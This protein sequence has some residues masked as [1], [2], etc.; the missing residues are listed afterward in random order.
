MNS[1]PS[2]A[3]QRIEGKAA[4]V[5]EGMP[6][7]RV[8]PSRLRRMVGA[9]CFLD[10]IGPAT[11]DTAG[12]LRVG[13][14]PHIGLQT[15]TWLVE[16]EILHRDSLGSLQVIKPGQLNVM[17]SGRAISHSEESPPDAPRAIHGV[18]FWTV[19]PEAERWREP[20]FDHYATLPRLQHEGLSMILI[21]GQALGAKSPARHFWPT[22][23]LEISAT[24]AVDTQLPLDPA[25]EHAVLVLGGE[26]GIAGEPLDR[27]TLLYFAPGLDALSVRCGAGCRFMLIG[28][29]PFEEEVLMWWNFVGRSREELTRACQ[30]WN[31]GPAQ[32]GQVHGYDGERLMAPMPP[33][34]SAPDGA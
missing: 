18:Q 10:H 19:L 30:E 5:G 11:L 17:T 21:M 34:A 26:A 16:G 28:G 27:D 7:S 1:R 25:F 14:H 6:I 12:A 31:D 15:V 3:P 23:A 32:F 24:D 2:A 22:V 13:P 33:W 4:I 9:W 8:L 29:R 20:L